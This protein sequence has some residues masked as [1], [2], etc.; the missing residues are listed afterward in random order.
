VLAY[1]R[2][3]ALL[4]IGLALA[5]QAAVVR[6]ASLL[7]LAAGI[8]GGIAGE[9]D[10]ANSAWVADHLFVLALPGPIAC[11]I[12]GLALAL[13]LIV[14]QWAL[15]IL[16]AGFGFLIG[17]AIGL[18]A[19][20]GYTVGFAAGGALG[21]LWIAVTPALLFPPVRVGWARI[22]VRILGS[23]LIAIGIMLGGTRL[24]AARPTP[25]TLQLQQPPT[26][27]PMILPR[28]GTGGEFRQ[29]P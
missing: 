20:A 9:A 24:I 7:T 5:G 18:A 2:A 21:G 11:V 16:A 4:G 25:D 15:P 27:P 3:L 17:V 28:H 10:L 8:V 29:E 12:A 14:Q 22:L 6:S 19:P 23:W 1:E 13:P 26:S